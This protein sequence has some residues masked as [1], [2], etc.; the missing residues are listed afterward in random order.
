VDGLQLQ[1][2]DN[3]MRWPEERVYRAG[4]AINKSLKGGNNAA[5]AAQGC[6]FIEKSMH[7]ERFYLL[8]SKLSP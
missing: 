2:V 3:K 1:G 5:A 4:M 6:K 8:L 7:R